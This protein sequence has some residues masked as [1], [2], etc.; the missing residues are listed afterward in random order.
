[1]GLKSYEFALVSKKENKALDV[2]A[3]MKSLITMDAY[4]YIFLFQCK[5]REIWF[6]LGCLV[7]VNSLYG[8]KGISIF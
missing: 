7:L 4:I 5:R 3:I 1:M 8:S 2:G 6:I